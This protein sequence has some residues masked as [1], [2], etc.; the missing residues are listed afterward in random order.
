[1]PSLVKDES[2]ADVSTD[3]TPSVSVLFLIARQNVFVLSVR[4]ICSFV[5]DF[6]AFS[7]DPQVHQI[8]FCCLMLLLLSPQG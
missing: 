7:D 2:M 3:V 8:P 5:P 1:M 4:Y 6:N